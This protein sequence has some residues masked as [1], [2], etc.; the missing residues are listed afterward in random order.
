MVSFP[1]MPKH[2]H[3]MPDGES[4]RIVQE[5]IALLTQDAKETSD[6]P[7]GST[8]M[9][10]SLSPHL[11]MTQSPFASWYGTNSGSG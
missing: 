1:W 7:V 8:Y 9:S 2:Q 11:L 5:V 6:I 10:L 4:H 3:K